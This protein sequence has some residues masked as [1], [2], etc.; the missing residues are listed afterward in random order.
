[1]TASATREDLE[2]ARLSGMDDHIAKPIDSRRLLAALEIHLG[3][4]GNALK[5]AAAPSTPRGEPRVVDL[6]R[7]LDRLQG[8]RDLLDELVAQFC[9]EAVGT[10]GQLRLLLEQRAGDELGFAVHRLRGQALSLDAGRLA[11]TLGEL[12][13]LV[14][15]GQWEACASALHAVD[16]AIDQLLDVLAPR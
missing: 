4:Y 3:G 7:A 13:A 15:R 9:K 1:L 6:G 8:N 5:L 10:R 14:G 11:M 2:R 16:H 12:E